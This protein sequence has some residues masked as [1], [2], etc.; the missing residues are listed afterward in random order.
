MTGVLLNIGIPLPSSNPTNS[1]LV[2]LMSSI[3]QQSLALTED[4]ERDLWFKNP[5]PKHIEIPAHGSSVVTYLTI[6]RGRIISASDDHSIHVYSPFDGTLLQKLDGHE[7]GVWSVQAINDT[8][9]S[10]STDRTI[11]VWDISSGRCK[12]IFG[13]HTSTIRCLAV[14]TP[15]IE[16]GRDGTKIVKE[17]QA[18]RA[19][20]VSGSRDHSLRVW[21]LPLPDE[22]EYSCFEDSNAEDPAVDL[23]SMNTQF[24]V[25]INPFN[26]R[27]PWT[28]RIIGA[29]LRDM[30]TQYVV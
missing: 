27:M 2:S 23:F 29:H 30:S 13:G 16:F 4:Q 7:G 15:E 3:A 26:K 24:M 12:H 28:I 11:R 19:L 18:D 14:V 9:I 22:D 21:T 25:L 1:D 5:N 10:G 20:I 6:S 8:L 17:G